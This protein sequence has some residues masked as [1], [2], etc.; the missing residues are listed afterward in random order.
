M[1]QQELYKI[2][3]Q[4]ENIRIE[5]KEAQGGV[6][7]SFYDTVVSFLN[8]EGGVILL[9][10]VDNGTV[11]GLGEQNL[12][13]LKQDIV[14]ALNNPDVVNPPFPLAV[15]E[16]EHSNG[17]LLYIHVPISSIVHKHGVVIYDR[18]NDSDFRITDE[19]RIAEMYARKRNVFTENQIFS[20]LKIEDLN[21]SLFDKVR[22]RLAF[23]NANHPWLEASNERILRDARFLRRDYTSG[24]EGLTLA[25]ALV[26]GTDEVIGNILPAYRIDILERRV[27]ID[28]WDDRLLLK[29]NL[30]DSYLKA[31]SFIKG[32]WPE[33]FY[34]D[35]NGDRKDLRELIFRELVGNII[36]HR[37]YNSATPTEVIIYEDRVETTN[38]NRMRFRGPLDL[39]TFNAEP[40]NPNI[41]AFFNVLT[42]ADEIGSGVKNMNK[43]V[44]AYT[45]GAHPMFIEDEP[46]L[47]II[48][49]VKFEVGEMYRIYRSLALLKDEE[50]GGDRLTR[51]M[52][53]P[54]DLSL[55]EL[56]D[57][58]ELAF[59]LVRSWLQKSEELS[60]FRFLIN[61][62]I[63]IDKLKKVGSWE[64]KS[65]EL[66]KKRGRI[67]LGTLLLTILP[68]SL[69]ELAKILGYKRKERYRDDYVT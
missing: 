23:S 49:M 17:K 51:L 65:G 46:F 40:K 56:T 25:A 12:M 10:V 13:N 38:P 52:S 42:W 55:K 68:I 43:F 31:L 8:R 15:N 32:K 1:T 59:Q 22:S 33:K 30:I 6:P 26:F 37:E 24:I 50:L 61:S 21:T 44:I 45:G 58:D 9:G 2:L 4:G 27:D 34:Q 35:K 63:P 19:A 28:R 67:L 11:L 5:F 3:N 66:L 18:E 41:R 7:D 54:L 48:P 14:T 53:F 20:H 62:N 64:E 47:S 29:T 16:V 36:I 69:E 57:W 39:E 60:N